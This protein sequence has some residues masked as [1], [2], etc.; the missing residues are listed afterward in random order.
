MLRYAA[1]NMSPS[2]TGMTGWCHYMWG[3]WSLCF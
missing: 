1:T 3:E 2:Y